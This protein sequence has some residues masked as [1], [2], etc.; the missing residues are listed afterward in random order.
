MSPTTGQPVSL[1]AGGEPRGVPAL[2]T[3]PHVLLADISEFQPDLADAAYLAWSKAIIVRACYGT[4]H[5][6]KAWYGGTRRDALHKGGARFVGLYQYIVASQDPVQ[7]AR[8]L[9]KLVG[10]LRPGEL[11]I[12]DWEEGDGDQSARWKA[13]SGEIESTYHFAPWMY[14]GLDYAATHGLHPQWV[15]AYQPSEPAPP[16]LLW[17]FT[18]AY[19]VPGVGLADCSLYHGTIDQLAANAWHPLPQRRPAV[20]EEDMMQLKTGKGNSDVYAFST[21]VK[22]IALLSDPGGDGLKETE[23]RVALHKAGKVWAVQH[24]SLTPDAPRVTITVKAGEY[25]GVR[26]SRLDAGGPVG[27]AFA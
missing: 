25:D 10:P 22:E 16:H 2:P 11:L 27:V 17:Q 19:P 8:A 13:W 20:K 23:I 18:D 12:A 4:S 9:A 24:V 1:R 6:D 7:Q 26:F 15:A 5:I 3:T 21:P 14:S